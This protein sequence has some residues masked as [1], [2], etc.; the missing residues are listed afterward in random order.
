[1]VKFYQRPG[2]LR[3]GQLGAQRTPERKAF[4]MMNASVA[5]LASPPDFVMQ[6]LSAISKELP[7]DP[8]I[9]TI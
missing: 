4:V 8:P 9:V 6:E 2:N 5:R 7:P 3:L 1:L